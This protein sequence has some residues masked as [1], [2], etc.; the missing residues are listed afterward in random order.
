MGTI[1]GRFISWL[2]GLTKKAK[3]EIELLAPLAIKL[4]EGIKAAQDN[5]VDDIIVAAINF[6]TKGTGTSVALKVEDVARE[7]IPKI[8]LDLKLSTA[9]L[10]ITDPNE[11]LQ[12]ILN[13]LTLSKDETKAIV[14]HGFASMILEKLSDGR[15]SWNDATEITTEYWKL[16]KAGKL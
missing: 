1:F 9:I 8:L 5:H 10:K 12:A 3:T 4:V 6:A 2:K 15:I 16:H 11:Q 13:L 7:W 14:Y